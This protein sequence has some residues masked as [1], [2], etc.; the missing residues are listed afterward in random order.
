LPP[1]PPSVSASSPG[2]AAPRRSPARRLA[3]LVALAAILVLFW[4]LHLD[5][6]V[7]FATLR[8]N[9]AILTAFV[10]QYRAWAAL[11]FVALYVVVIA[12]SLPIGSLLS[13]A[14]GFLFGTILGTLCVLVGAT[15]GATLLFL[16]AKSAI[17]DSLRRRMG[18]LG[19]R[20]ARDLAQN[21]FSY[22]LVLRLVPLFPFWLVNLVPAAAGIALRVYV[23]ATFLGIIPATAVYVSIGS[24]LGAVLERGETPDLSTIFSWSVLGPL[25]GLAGLALIPVIYR[26]IRR[27][28]QP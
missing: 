23:L 27:P 6:Y 17:G 12:A 2:D 14:G 7:N 25:L 5:R 22:L 28:S 9:R 15:I 24:G 26:R 19:D 13:I 8:D 21:A 1:P 16:A 20:L 11:L 4:A 10:A 18:P 3:P